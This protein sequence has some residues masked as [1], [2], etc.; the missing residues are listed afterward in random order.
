MLRVDNGDVEAELKL[1][2][3]TM[4]YLALLP[5]LRSCYKFHML[6]YAPSRQPMGNS[7]DCLL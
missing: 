4:K 3:C 6:A 2:I 1:Y 7:D 5:C